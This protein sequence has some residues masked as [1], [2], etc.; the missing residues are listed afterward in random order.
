M[1][2]ELRV[3]FPAKLQGMLFN[4]ARYKCAYGGRGGGKSV[5]FAKALLVK[6]TEKPLRILCAREI[7]R[8]IADSVHKLLSD[9]I[10]RMGM[11]GF[12]EIQQ[13]VIKGLNGTEIT[14]AGLK[15]NIGNIKSV[16][17]TDICWCEEAQTVSK[18]SWEVLIPTIRKDDSEIWVTFNPELDDDE[19]YKRFVLKPPANALVVKVNHN[20]NPW[21]P[22]VLKA[23]M[24]ELKERDMDAYLHIYEGQCR[25]TL[26]GSV[27]SNEIRVATMNGQ[28]RSVPYDASRPVH[29]FWDLGFNDHTSI[30]FAQ[31]VG[32]ELRLIDF[33]QDR[34]RSVPWYL[35]ALQEKGYVY[36]EDWLPHD[37]QAKTLA[38]AMSVE[39]IMRNAGRNVRITP[40]LSI[41]DGINAVRTV[42]NRCLF[43]EAKC[44]DGIQCLRRYSYDVDP[45]TGRFSRT[46]LHNEY[47]DGADAFRYFAVA[48]EE[49]HAKTTVR[50]NFASEFGHRAFA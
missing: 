20:D 39:Q 40:K 24:A 3:Q 43:D 1:S 9:Q 12:Y 32:A 41:Q 6:G 2:G 5:S 23:E 8:S 50:I 10:K 36:A 21:F 22:G 25:Q 30:W 31:S 16:E 28:F 13:T 34:G 11:E 19:T 17:G 45:N 47:S 42:F 37:A 15:H 27:Y 46:P 4:P 35:S 33:L 14:F 26:E 7:Q 48:T 18:S 29:T 49:L 44:A 38:A